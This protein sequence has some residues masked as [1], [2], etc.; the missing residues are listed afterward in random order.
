MLVK[1]YK[2]RIKILTEG[3]KMCVGGK[4]R[5]VVGWWVIAISL[6]VDLEQL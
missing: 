1:M 4:K 2:K 5:A 3:A 6:A